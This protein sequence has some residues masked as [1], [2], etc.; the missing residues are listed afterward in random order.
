MKISK[1]AKVG[2]LALVS[3]VILYTGFNYLKGV[4]MFRSS[5]TYWAIYDKISGLKV[6]NEVFVN[7]LVVGRVNSIEFH[8]AEENKMLVGID[9]D[10]DILL[11]NKTEAVLT[12]ADILGMGGKIIDIKIKK[13]SKT[14]EGGDTLI[15]KT[16]SAMTEIIAE[17]AMPLFTQADTMILVLNNML[18]KYSKMSEKIELGIESAT[19]TSDNLNLLIAQNKSK[20]NSL[21]VDLNEVSS[22]LVKSQKKLNPLLDKMDTFADSLNSLEMGALVKD[23]RKTLSGVQKSI[24]AIN[25][26]EG[27]LG[28]LLKEDSIYLHA[29]QTTKDLDSLLVDFK[30]NPKR[31]VHFSLFGKKDKTKKKKK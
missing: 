29:D 17:K 15:S 27:T 9:V 6:S 26:A 12:D 24:D 7:G 25:K 11:N 20:M 31:Y 22:S 4:E 14:I 19:R 28:K 1:E 23:T 10:S 21:M 2:L 18:R 5:S 30:K 16:P 3:G 13:G 8:Q